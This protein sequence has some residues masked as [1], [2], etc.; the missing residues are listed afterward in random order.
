MAVPTAGRR[1]CPCVN[2]SAL[3]VLCLQEYRQLVHKQYLEEVQAQI[4]RN[5]IHGRR[6]SL[7]Q[8]PQRRLMAQQARTT[9]EHLARA[10]GARISMLNT[11]KLFQQQPTFYKMATVFPEPDDFDRGKVNRVLYYKQRPQTS[12]LK[13]EALEAMV[14]PKKKRQLLNTGPQAPPRTPM[15]LS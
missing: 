9:Q 7:I 8:S 12:N 13:A 15:N 11:E 14:A 10:A 4:A 6:S 3:R 5:I 1:P 2:G